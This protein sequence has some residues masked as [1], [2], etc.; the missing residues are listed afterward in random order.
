MTCGSCVARVDKALRT[1]DAVV[2]AKVNLATETATVD[3]SDSIDLTKNLIRAVRAAGYDAEPFKFA[4]ADRSDIET[5]QD[6]RLR[7]AKQAL[8]QAIGLALPIIGL[9]LALPILSGSHDGAQVGPRA[10]QAILC[11][12]LFISPAGA[13]ILVGGLRAAWF[14]APNMDLLITIGVVA[15]FGSSLAATV[16]PHYHHFHYHAVGMILAFINIG[17]YL[18]GKAK[19]QAASAVATL[20]RRAPTKALRVENGSTRSI[21]LSDIYL[22]DHLRVAADTTVPVDGTILDGQAAID[23]SML[24]GESVPVDRA[25]GDPVRGG[26]LL[27]TGLITIVATSTGSDSAIAKIIRMV[28][29]AQTSKT[30][31]QRFA[32]RV[33]GVFVPIVI[34]LA[35]LTLLAWPILSNAAAPWAM[36]LQAA[37]AVLVIACPCAMGL[38]TPTAVM[39]ATGTAGLR[40]IL[41]RDAAALE[42]AGQIKTIVFDKTGTLT[43]GSPTL[44]TILTIPNPQNALTE[45]ELLTLA[46]SAE[47]FSQHPL[48]KAIVAKAAAADI[49]LIEP[50][51]YET[52][53]GLGVQCQLDGKTVHVGSFKYFTANRI[54]TDPLE[55]SAAQLA[56]SGQTIVAL[57]V[58]HQ[59]AGLIGL[60]DTLRSH[61][62]DLINRL[63]DRRISSV[64]VTG[65]QAATAHAVAEQIGIETVFAGVDPAG[66]VERVKTLQHTQG[67]VAMV[68][69]GINDAP[70]L[71][72]ADVGIAFA[73]GTD[74]A[75]EAADIT[76]VAPNL[77]LVAEAVDLARRSVRIIKQNLFWAF[78]YNALA[79]PLAATGRISPIWAAGAMMCSSLSVVLNSLRLRRTP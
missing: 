54:D 68:G 5:Q 36:G 66:K 10:F 13:P 69:D 78:F 59:P 76:L 21:S 65:D 29:E 72:A 12:M 17:R 42:T 7:R 49:P 64:M 46:A 33:A 77:L 48:A 58:N 9:D 51:Q 50:D 70:A 60:S 11:V 19:R 25:P 39:V 57:A 26:T 2:D 20:I 16:L 41:V 28:E 4:A 52:A 14:R 15:A 31:L 3:L 75:A 79:I 38:A 67:P 47:Q 22:G 63:T 40:G 71:V 53:A 32:D 35:A 44:D 18:E 24:T 43:T 61:A 37:I 1:V 45:R 27:K 56:S 30:Q 6:E 62:A 73:T 23:E 74:V 55:P 8:V 34:A